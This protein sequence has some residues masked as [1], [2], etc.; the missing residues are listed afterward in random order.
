[1][2]RYEI[3]D[4]TPPKEILHSM[5]AQ[6][7]AEREKRAVIATSEGKRQEQINLAMGARERRSRSRKAR[8]RPRSTRRRAMRRRSSRAPRRPRRRSGSRR[9]ADRA[10]WPRRGEPARGAEEYIEQFGKLARTTNTLIL[11]SNVADVGWLH[12]HRDV[13]DP[14]GRAA[15]GGTGRAAA[16]VTR[17]RHA[18][19]LAC[20]RR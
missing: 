5:Q 19:R 18:G 20:S 10:G 12:R 9:S 11:P 2:L 17:R 3:K 6:I 7:T 4:L 15:A 8:S 1:V 13:G 14:R 16:R